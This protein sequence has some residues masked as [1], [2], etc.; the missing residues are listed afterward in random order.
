MVGGYASVAVV[1]RQVPDRDP[2]PR[3]EVLVEVTRAGGHVVCDRVETQ[4]GSSADFLVASLMLRASGRTPQSGGRFVLGTIAIGAFVPAS[5][6]ALT[7]TRL[8]DPT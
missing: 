5:V 6:V 1:S 3:V 7:R 4:W 2:E 8:M